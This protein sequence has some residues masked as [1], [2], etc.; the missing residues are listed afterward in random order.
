MG[1]QGGEGAGDADE[2][3]DEA[4]EDDGLGIGAQGAA[5]AAEVAFELREDLGERELDGEVSG[6]RRGRLLPERLL[7]E[8]GAGVGVEEAAQGRP[9]VEHEVVDPVAVVEEE[10]QGDPEREDDLGGVVP[11][12]GLHR[13][14]LHSR[15]FVAS[16]GRFRR[17]APGPWP[18]A[19][20]GPRR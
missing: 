19:A 10:G 11:G 16:A 17:A 9:V 7:H 4:D 18:E 12:S 3:A 5:A 14:D 6:V 8:P 20:P 15:S 2:G 1:R 13:S